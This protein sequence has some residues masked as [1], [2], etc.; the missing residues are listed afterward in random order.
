MELRLTPMKETA[1]LLS[2]LCTLKMIITTTE[3]SQFTTENQYE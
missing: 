1:S 2:N 3:C